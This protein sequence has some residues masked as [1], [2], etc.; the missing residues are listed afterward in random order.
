MYDRACEKLLHVFG[1][2]VGDK[3]RVVATYDRDRVEPYYIRENLQQDVEHTF[4]M[5]HQPLWN[6]HRAHILAGRV[7]PTFGAARGSHHVYD[8]LLLYQIPVNQR[9][10]VYVSFDHCVG[11]KRPKLSECRDII[12]EVEEDSEEDLSCA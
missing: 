1:E 6:I 5:L 9:G 7:I 3:L 8:D 4:D 12:L 10:G 2:S 11:T